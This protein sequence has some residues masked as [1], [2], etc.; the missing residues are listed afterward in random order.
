MHMQYHSYIGYR[1]CVFQ[2]KM[3]KMFTNWFFWL[4]GLAWF[5]LIFL[6]RFPYNL[7]NR[8]VFAAVVIVLLVA[9]VLLLLL[10]LLLFTG[11]YENGDRCSAHRQRRTSSRVGSS[12]P[13]LPHPAKAQFQLFH[14]EKEMVQL[15]FLNKRLT[16][17]PATA[18]SHR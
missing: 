18:I 5:G 13:C 1:V 15:I 10:F 17:S 9:H 14:W 2:H 4:R 6:D 7:M 8:C 3:P 16:R 11:N 12:P